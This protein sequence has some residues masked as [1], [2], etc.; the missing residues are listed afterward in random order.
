MVGSITHQS[1]IWWNK[2]YFKS[3]YD[4][5]QITEVDETIHEDIRD[6]VLIKRALKQKIDV[7]ITELNEV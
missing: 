2:E 3:Y 7:R 4:Q 6:A 5:L 1:P